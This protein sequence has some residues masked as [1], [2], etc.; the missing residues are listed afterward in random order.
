MKQNIKMLGICASPRKDGNTDILLEKVLEGAREQGI[1][2]EKIFLSDLNILSLEEK[3]YENVTEEGLSVRR[4]DM[5][6]VFHKVE[7]CDILVIGS[8]IF[9]GSL[10]SQAKTMID[11][12]QCVWLAKE[13]L[14]KE[15]FQKKK[16]G[17]FVS[18]EATNRE[19]FFQNA[20]SIIRNFFAVIN[21]K[22][23][24]E[25]FCGGADA[26]RKVLERPEVLKQA[27]ELGVKL[28]GADR[29]AR[30]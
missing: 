19:D 8:P 28:V 22:Y 15:I 10:S 12:F 9:F 18:V 6:I 21:V 4:D 20:K 30:P 13:I 24:G 17:A 25:L 11:R 26:K 1:Q 27:Y 23:A 7:D 16:K 29:R 2:T 14:K 3:E 5:R